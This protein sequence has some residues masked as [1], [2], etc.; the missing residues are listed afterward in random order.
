MGR[1]GRGATSRSRR[2][3]EKTKALG[4]APGLMLVGLAG[5]SG[6]GLMGKRRGRGGRRRSQIEETIGRRARLGQGA[7]A[8]I[9]QGLKRARLHRR[10]PSGARPPSPSHD[11]SG[12]QAGSAVK[13]LGEFL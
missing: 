6:G 1:G 4:P 8:E 3:R 9:P 10:F 5:L 2:G 7:G 13:P 11:S 12:T